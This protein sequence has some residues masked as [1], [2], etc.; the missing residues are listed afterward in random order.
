MLINEILVDKLSNI[1]FIA[2]FVFL[3]VIILINIMM[4]LADIKDNINTG[5]ITIFVAFSIILC[6]SWCIID[7]S[8]PTKIWHIILKDKKI[9]RKTYRLFFTDGEID[10]KKSGTVALKKQGGLIVINDT[11]IPL[12]I[13]S[14]IYY[15]SF[16]KIEE[17]KD[18]AEEYKK[19]NPDI[20]ITPG[21]IHS[22]VRIDYYGFG[23]YKPPEDLNFERS[24]KKKYFRGEKVQGICTWLRWDP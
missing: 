14:V 24:E 6:I 10:T 7:G 8:N 19:N 17:I 15:N 18:I 16:F 3:G 20:I 1:A 11:D 5:K 9:S 23:K 12:I 22:K 13:E 21:E 4:S 2:I